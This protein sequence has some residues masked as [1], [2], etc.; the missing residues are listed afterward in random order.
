[1]VT[2][3]FRPSDYMSVYVVVG[4]SRGIGFELVSQ[5]LSSYPGSLVVAGARDPNGSS[6]LVELHKT[7]PERLHLVKIDQDHDESV[8]AA[9]EEVALKHPN[10]IDYLINNAAIIGKAENTPNELQKVFATNA[11]GPFR[12]VQAFLPL[13]RKGKKKVIVN[14]SSFAGTLAGLKQVAGFYNIIHPNGPS[15][16]AYRT[17]KTAL[18][19]LTLALAHDLA[20]EGITVIPLHPGGVETDMYYEAGGT[21]EYATKANILTPADSA[22]A[23]LEVIQKLNIEDSGKFFS[24]TG[25]ILAL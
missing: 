1:L 13:I 11:V 3:L 23:Q 7:H 20:S 2:Y 18:N 24:Y 16:Y 6:G 15:F 21:K 25:E 14:V 10:G 8:K 12:L 4:A 17:S 19:A 5:L 22:K 9:A